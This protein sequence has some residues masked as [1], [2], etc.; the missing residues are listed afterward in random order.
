MAAKLSDLESNESQAITRLFYEHEWQLNNGQEGVKADHISG[1]G[2]C[3]SCLHFEYAATDFRVV[4][5]TCSVLEIKLS[6]N[7][8]ITHCNQYE[9]RGALTLNQMVSMAY[10][11]ETSRNKVGFLDES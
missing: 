9:K 11:L 7:D 6:D 5:S 8:P 4:L 2:L 3:A 10:L 1:Y